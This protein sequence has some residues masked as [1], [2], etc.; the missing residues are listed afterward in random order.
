VSQMVHPP[1]GQV[2]VFSQVTCRNSTRVRGSLASN[3][4]TASS[5]LAPTSA[6]VISGE[7]GLLGP[8]RGAA[9]VLLDAGNRDELV[10]AG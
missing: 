8:V 10:P 9:H 6:R 1:A 5:E 3:T 4:A 2:G 7:L